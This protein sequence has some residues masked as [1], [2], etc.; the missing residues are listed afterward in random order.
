MKTTLTTDQQSAMLAST[1][2]SFSGIWKKVAKAAQRAV[3]NRRDRLVDVARGH[4]H[5]ALR[6][7]KEAGYWAEHQLR[8]SSNAMTTDM[9]M[10]V[11]NAP[12]FSVRGSLSDTQ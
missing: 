7:R 6:C 8:K 4:V 11:K 10:S 2:K 3:G 9:H 1:E 5:F 12:I